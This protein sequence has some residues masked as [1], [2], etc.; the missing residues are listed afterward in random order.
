VDDLRAH[1]ALARA[2]ELRV[3]GPVCRLPRC[4][5]A[6]PAC[7]RAPRA[8]PTRRA[9]LSARAARRSRAGLP[10]RERVG[11]APRRLPRRRGV[12]PPP[13]SSSRSPRPPRTPRASKPAACRR[14][15]CKDRDPP[16]QRRFSVSD[17]R[18]PSC[19]PAEAW[20]TS[21]RRAKPS[22]SRTCIFG[23][24][25]RCCSSRRAAY[26]SGSCTAHRRR[27][28]PSAARELCVQRRGFSHPNVYGKGPVP[29]G[30]RR[31]RSSRRGMRRCAAGGR[32]ADGVHAP[33]ERRPLV[34]RRS[35]A[36]ARRG[37]PPLR[38]RACRR[39]RAHRPPGPSRWRFVRNT[40]CT[41]GCPAAQPC[42]AARAGR[43]RR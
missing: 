30:W 13:P 25:P 18:T 21:S 17:S 43:G 40:A 10:R 36:R 5:P 33:R 9:R 3:G 11:P 14:Y 38:R 22:P 15:P 6:P 29:G 32:V 31:A 7:P 42:L 26:T 16:A 2:R 37:A 8:R 41:P 23:R 12:R 4:G 24:R 28:R 39:A 27:P 1:G 34:V 35:P 20:R 19:G